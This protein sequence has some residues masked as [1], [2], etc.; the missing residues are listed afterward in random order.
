MV[1][2]GAFDCSCYKEHKM[3]GLKPCKMRLLNTHC[4]YLMIVLIQS[5]ASCSYPPCKTSSIYCRVSVPLEKFLHLTEKRERKARDYSAVPQIPAVPVAP[6]ICPQEF[7]IL[8]CSCRGVLEP[9]FL[10]LLETVLAPKSL[11]P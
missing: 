3:R 7:K 1:P 8:V 11:G 4:Y 6:W 10:V 9:F 5:L 2:T